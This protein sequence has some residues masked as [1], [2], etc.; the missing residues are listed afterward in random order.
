LS[1]GL[2]NEY[3]Q[4][5]QNTFPLGHYFVNS[6]DLGS[7]E[8]DIKKLFKILFS[9]PF[10]TPSFDESMMF[11]AYTEARRSADLS[12]QIGAIIATENGEIV[13]SGFNDV[14]FPQFYRHN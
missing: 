1:D 3:G 8:N 7:L 11:H 10:I 14:I 13:A 6:D 9:Y 12:R 2:D 4:D 5:V